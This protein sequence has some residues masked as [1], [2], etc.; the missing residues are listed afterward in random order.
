MKKLEYKYSFFFLFGLFCVVVL[1]FTIFISS[2]QFNPIQNKYNHKRI[3]FSLTPQG[4]A[5]FTRNPR[6]AQTL[7][8][9]IKKDKLV[10]L[11]HKHSSIYNWIGLN[12]KSSVIMSEMQIIRSKLAD[13]IF[14]NSEWNYQINKTG[15]FPKKNTLVKNEIF[16]PILCGEYVLVFQ[17]PIAWAYSKSLKNI[18]MPAK[19]ARIKINCND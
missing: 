7:I 10:L 1:L 4:W 15:N 17:K 2:I 6:E 9:E 18:S 5:F 8:Y 3:V 11:N 16:N 19:V 13:S 12:R 14:I